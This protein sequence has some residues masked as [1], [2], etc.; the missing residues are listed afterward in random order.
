MDELLNIGTYDKDGTEN[1]GTIAWTVTFNNAEHGN[2]KSSTGWSGQRQLL[3]GDPVIR[4]TWVLTSQTNVSDNWKST[5]I[6]QDFFSRC[7]P[8]DKNLRT[9]L[10]SKGFKEHSM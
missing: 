1:G 3:N 9:T 6:S 4:T 10:I 7:F 5:M 8:K 2:S